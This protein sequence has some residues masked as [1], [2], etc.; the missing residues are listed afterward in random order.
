MSRVLVTTAYLHPGDDVHALRRKHGHQ[1]SYRPAVGPRDP[2]EALA[3]F[4]G[5]HGAIVASEPITAEMLDH[6]PEL[7]VLARSGIGYDSID[8]AA[9]RTAVTLRCE[10]TMDSW[11]SSFIRGVDADVGVGTGGEG[12]A[13]PV[14]QCAAGAVGVDAGA[15]KRPQHPVLQGA[16]GDATVGTHEQRR[17]RRPGGQ[18]PAGAGAVMRGGAS[19][20]HRRKYAPCIVARPSVS[21]EVQIPAGASC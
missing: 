16:A 2:D 4:D 13:Q 6:A 21:A 20:V 15:P 19:D 1:V 18:S 5:V 11:P 17:R 14:D 9:A 12:V 3:L 10:V 7:K 8:V